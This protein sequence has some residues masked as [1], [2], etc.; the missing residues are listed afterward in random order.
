MTKARRYPHR[1]RMHSE[2]SKDF[3]CLPAQPHLC[4]PPCLTLPNVIF[5][6]SSRISWTSRTTKTRTCPRHSCLRPRRSHWTRRASARSCRSCWAACATSMRRGD[7]GILAVRAEGAF[8]DGLLCPACWVERHAV[9][10]C[11]GGSK[12]RLSVCGG[13]GAIV[14]CLPCDIHT[15]VACSSTRSEAKPPSTRGMTV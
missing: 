9:V 4:A 12:C 10:G 11:A 15:G 3:L 2:A 1:G 13:A 14:V 7:K 8:A 5:A 6:T